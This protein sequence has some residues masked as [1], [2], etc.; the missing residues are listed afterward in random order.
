MT[1]LSQDQ[2]IFINNIATVDRRLAIWAKNNMRA[3][4][5]LADVKKRLGEL[6]IKASR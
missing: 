4:W 3:G 1:T 2:I 5:S 6:M